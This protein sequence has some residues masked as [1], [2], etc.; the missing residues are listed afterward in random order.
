[1]SFTRKI[2]KVY[3]SVR[4][5]LCM[6]GYKRAEYIR[7]HKLFGAMGENCYFH[8]WKL[9]ADS[10]M[11][12][13]HDNVAVAAN[14]TFVNHDIAGAM[15]NRKNNTSEFQYFVEP[16]EIHDNV[17]IGTNVT[18]LPCVIGDNVV[19]G[20]GSVVSKNLEGGGVYAGNPIR[21]LGEF[22]DFEAK[23]RAYTRSK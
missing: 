22:A 15:L 4:L 19:V 17:L 5:L 14:V 18:V 2:K 1:M 3:H 10:Q 9:P 21:K 12:F 23:R 20:A 7:K 13:L 16:I 11:I 8:P 6:E